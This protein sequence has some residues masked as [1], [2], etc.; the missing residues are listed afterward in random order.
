MFSGLCK[1]NPRFSGFQQQD[2]HDLLINL[3]DMLNT[4]HDLLCKRT[5]EEKLKGLRKSV[6][7][8]AFGGFFMNRGNNKKMTTSVMCLECLHVSK[9]V[10][11]MLE[12]SLTI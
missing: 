6:V 11:P 1:R 9:T 12:M 5:K 7:E 10:E 8:E 2:A 3:L 4:E